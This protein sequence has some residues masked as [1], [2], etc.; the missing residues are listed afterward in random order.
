MRIIFNKYRNIIKFIIMTLLFIFVIYRLK[1]ELSTID[2]KS[3]MTAFKHLDSIQLALLIFSGLISVSI[4]SL[5]DFVLAKRLNMEIKYLK[6][7]NVSFIANA[8]NA[9]IGF[10]GMIGAGLR[11]LTYRNYTEDDKTL[12]KVIS[13]MLLSMISGMSIL[14]LGI[15]F[16]I[17]PNTHAF[18][19]YTWYRIGIFII[20]L[21]LPIYLIY[22]FIKP[23]SNDKFL[24]LIFTLVSSIEW[25]AASGVFY[26]IFK[27]IHIDVQY[28]LIIGIFVIAALAGLLSMVPGGFGAF[29][30]MILIGFKSIG[31]SEEKILLALVMY[32]AVYY[33]VPF[34]VAMVLS[35][36]EFKGLAKKQFEER[37]EDNKYFAPAIET[38]S[39]FL[40]LLRDVLVFLPA[41][42]LGIL[43]FI[44]GFVFLMTNSILINDAIFDVQHNTYTFLSSLF[45]LSC[46]L[47]MIN[48]KGVMHDTRRAHIISIIAATVILIILFL[49]FGNW[50]VYIWVAVLILLLFIGNMN[51]KMIKRPITLMR[52]GLTLLFSVTILSLNSWLIRIQ[53]SELLAQDSIDFD[54]NLMRNYFL[55]FIIATILLVGLISYFFNKKYIANIAME[56]SEEQRAQIID[57]YG[58]N[59]VSHLHYST[60]KSYFINQDEDAFI[61]FQTHYDTIFVLGDPIGNKQSFRDLLYDFYSQANYY[62]YEIIFYQVKPDYL[63]LYHD[64]GNIF[65]KLGEEAMIPLTDFTISGKKKRAFRATVNK[66][67][68]QG[69]FYEIVHPPFSSDFV[70]RLQSVSDEWL[71]GRSE[72]NFSVGNFNEYYLNKAPVGVIRNEEDI[73]GFVS[74]MPTNYDHSIS[75]DMIRWKENEFQMMDG[76]YLN[77]ML[78]VKEQY[79][80][81]NMGMAPLSNVG[82]HKYAFYRERFAGRI[83]E[84]ISHIYSFKG[85]RNYK[86]KFNPIW[87]PRYLVYKKGNS[88]LTSMIRVSYLINKKTRN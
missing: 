23:V 87:Q 60:D 86:E 46:L 21:Y 78:S 11:L 71:D 57:N 12:I 42:A 6:L 84:T 41:I 58:G 32:R 62:G 75:V 33:F 52:A 73:I 35:T 76:L 14:S 16:N 22:T 68:S 19:Q 83:F 9:V 51:I 3:T 44:T 20:T 27:F 8:L 43:S 39:L 28:S 15:L 59:F 30:L 26:L 18:D 81:F 77:T 67:E 74:F 38:S 1:G 40:N 63:P 50:L 70:N 13:M 45:T 17:F 79:D 24:G 56:V 34:L 37:F 69:Y 47:L 53:L 31:I 5:Y 85:L 25:L 64:F 10:G 48:A 82:S 88:L 36:F 72:M 4:L 55:F 66:F 49:T 2:F 29:D 61:M 65:F 80:N 7:F 54:G